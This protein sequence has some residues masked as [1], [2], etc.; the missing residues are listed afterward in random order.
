[1]SE[2]KNKNKRYTCKWE[3]NC[4][5][6]CRRPYGDCPDNCP[7][8]KENK[9]VEEFEKENEQL[10][11][12]ISVL[13]S[14]KNCPENKGGYICEKEY[15]D[16]CLSQKIEY[17]KELK[18]QIEKMK[19]CKMTESQMHKLASTPITIDCFEMDDF[20]NLENIGVLERNMSNIW[21]TI[22]TYLESL[23]QKYN[24]TKDKRY[25][26]ELIRLLPSS[27]HWELAE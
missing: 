18:A 15:N 3:P 11:K 25:L 27:Y 23:R 10:K 4:D 8:Y 26:K 19:C 22:G 17:I 13:L 16:K 14:C 7:N 1:M 21:G 6:D 2:K 5:D 9:S 12:E 24:E 20:S